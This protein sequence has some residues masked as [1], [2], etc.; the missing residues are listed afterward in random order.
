M[1]ISLAVAA[2]LGAVSAQEVMMEAPEYETMVDLKLKLSN[3]EE[4]KR[5]H[6]Q[7]EHALTDFYDSLPADGKYQKA[8]FTKGE[9]LLATYTT[10][11][12]KTKNAMQYVDPASFSEYYESEKAKS[13]KRNATAAAKKKK[14]EEAA[15]KKEEEGDKKKEDPK[16]KDDK[17][18]EAEL[19]LAEGDKKEE[20]KKEDPKKKEEP[21]DYFWAELDN[22]KNAGFAFDS[23]VQKSLGYLGAND[24]ELSNYWIFQPQAVLEMEANDKFKDGIDGYK[25]MSE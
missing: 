23:H 9:D 16:K 15:K 2:L 5:A 24:G 21:K 13:A 7:Y 20:P 1:K 18:K 12:A 3:P 19:T 14:E 4:A 17:K 25:S 10:W 11:N 6:N 8:L 22:L